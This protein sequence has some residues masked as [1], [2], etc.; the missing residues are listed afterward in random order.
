MSRTAAIILALCL[1][2]CAAGA[3][4]LQG[5]IRE[6]LYEIT[7]SFEASG[8]EGMPGGMKMPGTTVQRCIGKKNVDQASQAILLQQGA[9]GQMPKDC[10][11]QNFNLSGNTATY[12]MACTG[13]TKMALEGSV[14]FSGDGFTA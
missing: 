11:V 5:Q 3:A 2:C 13:A 10:A 4:D 14:G 8:I 9:M 1:P 6:G 7:T 12:K